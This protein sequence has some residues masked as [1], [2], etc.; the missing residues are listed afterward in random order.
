MG[1]IRSELAGTSFEFDVSSAFDLLPIGVF[2]L[3]RELRFASLNRGLADMTG[4]PA[5]ALLGQPIGHIFPQLFAQL[6][7]PLQQA[8][9]GLS[10][11]IIHI[12]ADLF[13]A[14]GSGRN[15]VASLRPIPTVRGLS[16]GVLAAVLDRGHAAEA[17]LRESEE[18]FRTIVEMSPNVAWTASPDGQVLEICRHGLRIAGRPD[19]A[20]LGHR[21]REVV[22]PEDLP[23]VDRV[24]AAALRAGAVGDVEYRLRQADGSYRWVRARA[25]PR[26]DAEGRILRWYGTMAD[27]DPRKKAEAALRESEE[28]YRYAVELSPQIPWTAAPDGR[29]LESG[30]QLQALTGRTQEEILGTGWTAVLHPDDL[31]RVIQVWNH[32]LASGEPL[33]IEYRVRVVDGSWRWLRVRAAPRRDADGGILR[34]YGLAED[35]HDRRT[36]EDALRDSEAFAR[37]LLESSPDCMQVIDLDGRLQF[38]S[39]PGL[40]ALK[41]DDFAAV[42]GREWAAGFPAE[43][44]ARARQAMEKALSGRTARFIALCPTATGVEKWWDVS[45]CAIPDPAGRPARLLAVSR[46]ITRTKQA[47]DEI[48]R[49]RAQE[50]ATAERLSAVLESTTD[51]VVL[52]DRDWCVTYAN[53]RATALLAARGLGQ[54]EDIRHIFPR[55]ARAAS[56]TTAVGRASSK[57]RWTSRS[58]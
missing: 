41:I 33:D 40:R 28:R 39:D 12:P 16:R 7:R 47:Q 25:A 53:P 22:H 14:P 3:D 37:G 35:I 45:V 31:P 58:I 15:L 36:A 29:I 2:I 1:V 55:R 19:A 24:W 42:R 5:Q 38:I 18:H 54:G 4:L 43:G 57:A 23:E 8:L 50:R 44:Q 9:D 34:W 13:G 26:R 56:S 30:P 20:Y 52:L 32:S 11:E 46:D 10:S 21:W 27:I 51:G 49:M 17:A 6:Q 48:E